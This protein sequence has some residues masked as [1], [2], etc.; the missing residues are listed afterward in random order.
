LGLFGQV[1]E[2]LV[3]AG[4]NAEGFTKL[5]VLKAQQAQ[6]FQSGIPP[7]RSLAISL[8]ATRSVPEKASTSVLAMVNP[9]AVSSLDSFKMRNLG[10][11]GQDAQLELGNCGNT[12]KG[13]PV[14]I[15][16]KNDAGLGSIDYSLALT[17][18]LCSNCTGVKCGDRMQCI[19][20]T[21]M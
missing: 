7:G 14:F 13:M 21:G 11:N 5:G 12:G 16:I 20:A 9:G 2:A 10:H 8:R 1:V 3:L 6:V 19:E 17:V 15:G 18:R 4:A